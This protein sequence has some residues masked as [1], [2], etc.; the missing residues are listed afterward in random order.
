MDY[1]QG[2][3]KALDYVEEHIEENIDI[4]VLAKSSYC[5]TFNFQRIFT[6]LT[7]CTIS[8][9]I[10][11]RRLTLAGSELN[12]SNTKVIDVALKYGYDSPESFSRAF[13]KFHGI[14]PTDA[15]LKGATLKSFSRLSVKL[16]LKGGNI[17]NY[18][19]EEKDKFTILKKSVSLSEKWE[20]N[21]TIIP[22]F[23]EKC[24]KDGTLKEFSKLKNSAMFGN[25]ILGICF[26]KTDERP[27]EYAIATGTNSKTVPKGFTLEKIKKGT[28]AIFECGSN[29]PNAIQATWEKSILNSSQRLI[30]LQQIRLISMF[31]TELTTMMEN[32]LNQMMKATMLQKSS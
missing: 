22:R 26:N 25:S 19:I 8:E 13:S 14:N 10:R 12:S 5:S 32:L 27:G 28:W 29:E 24:H 17:M 31:I 21:A 15:K 7:G 20:D 3:Q 6:I 23:W 4:N 1:I 16:T 11:K 18:K 30:T 9:Y 2:I